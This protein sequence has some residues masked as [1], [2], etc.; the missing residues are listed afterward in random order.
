MKPQAAP[1]APPAAMRAGRDRPSFRAGT[2]ASCSTTDD[3][4]S[5][6]P[7][8]SSASSSRIAA[9]VAS[10]SIPASAAMARN[11]SAS[12]ESPRASISAA[13]F[14]MCATCESVNL[15]GVSFILPAL[16]S[17]RGFRNAPPPYRPAPASSVIGSS[18]LTTRVAG[19]AMSGSGP[20]T[21]SSSRSG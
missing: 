15:T 3:P 9:S 2:R 11:S 4:V 18:R 12:S 14:R 16:A 19:P 5:T 8:P 6:P 17:L 20:V 10:G 21:T 13:R 1:T 7:P